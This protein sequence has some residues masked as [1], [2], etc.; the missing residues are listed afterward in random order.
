[1]AF[2]SPE[3]F[4]ITRDKGYSMKNNF[5]VPPEQVDQWVL[6]NDK[7]GDERTGMFILPNARTKKGM[8]ILCKA[9]GELGWEHVS[10]SIP[11][12]NRCPTWEE[13][14]FVKD[15]FW[16]DPEDVVVQYHPA[17]K[18]YISQH[19]FCLHLWR[20]TETNFET[21]PSILVGINKK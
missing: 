5:R 11:S 10:I 12:E 15:L 19:D 8:F 6:A 14:C 3:Q 13:M 7:I 20:K 2:K 4:R 21:P 1:M 17:K 18:D 9:S 16:N